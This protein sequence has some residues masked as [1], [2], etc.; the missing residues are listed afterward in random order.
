VPPLAA[1]EATARA[2]LY[3]RGFTFA[4]RLPFEHDDYD[5]AAASD[6][7]SLGSGSGI[8]SGSS[9]GSSSDEDGDDSSDV[10]AGLFDKQG[11]PPEWPSSSRGHGAS[12]DRSE[13][14]LCA[15]LARRD[16]DVVVF[17]SVHRGR[18]LWVYFRSCNYSAS[19]HSAIDVLPFLGGIVCLE[20]VFAPLQPHTRFD[21]YLR[22]LRAHFQD[23]VLAAGYGKDRVLLLDGE[24]E[25]GAWHATHAELVKHGQLYVRE[26]PP[27][28]P[29][30]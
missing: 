14:A 25:N 18:P 22:S 30:E 27:G 20:L 2:G 5:P 26:M 7:G 29:A 23:A 6:F 3:G 4:H 13:A 8:S 19:F 24:D 9:S 12:L 15:A 16:F 1:V 21:N 10:W 28:C 17:G 11:G